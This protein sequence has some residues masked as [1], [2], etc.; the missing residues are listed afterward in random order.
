MLLVLLVTKDILGLGMVI[1]GFKPSPRAGMSVQ[2]PPQAMM[3]EWYTEAK[4]LCS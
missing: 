4:C 1:V 3:N 2:Y